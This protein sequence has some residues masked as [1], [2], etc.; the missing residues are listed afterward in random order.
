MKGASRLTQIYG[1]DRF[2]P[3]PRSC[4][5]PPFASLRGSRNPPAAVAPATATARTARATRPSMTPPAVPSP[6]RSRRLW[7]SSG[8]SNHCLGSTARTPTVTGHLS[9]RTKPPMISARSCFGRCGSRPT[10]VPARADS[11]RTLSAHPLR[12]ARRPVAHHHRPPEYCWRP[13]PLW[14]SE[15]LSRLGRRNG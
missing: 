8:P 14:R 6:M 9:C 7:G 1:R 2:H 5:R 13:N 15:S 12:H 3:G 4:S 10:P 11:V